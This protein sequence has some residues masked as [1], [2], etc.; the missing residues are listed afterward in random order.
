MFYH[1]A[2]ENGGGIKGALITV[3]GLTVEKVEELDTIN[4]LLL[5][6]SEDI[7]VKLTDTIILY[8]I[9]FIIMLYITYHHLSYT[10]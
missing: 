2:V 4:V 5:G 8:I 6:I 7:D 1:K 9:M 10:F 3:L